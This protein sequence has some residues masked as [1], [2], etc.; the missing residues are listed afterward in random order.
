MRSA[1]SN[2]DVGI[3][4]NLS[5]VY[6]ATD[7]P[8]IRFSRRERT[9]C[10]FAGTWT[11]CCAVEYPQDILEL[12]RRRCPSHPRRGHAMIFRT[13]GL[14]RRELLLPDRFDGRTPISFPPAK[15]SPSPT[16]VGKWR[17][18]SLLTCFCAWIGSTNYRP[19]SLP[20]NGAA[21]PDLVIGRRASRMKSGAPILRLTYGPS[22]TPIDQGVDVAR[23]F[24]WVA[25]STTLNGPWDIPSALGSTMSTMR[26]RLAFEAQRVW[27]KNL[28]DSFNRNPSRHGSHVNWDHGPL[29]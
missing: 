8:P 18:R 5:P 7:S 29:V 1:R 17:R 3:V 6:S 25:A 14:S 2:L 21:Y 23:L 10:W 11:P 26:R 9:A 27:Y 20:K 4:L 15:A 13:A 24:R 19:C 28:A 22:R 12:S 16:W